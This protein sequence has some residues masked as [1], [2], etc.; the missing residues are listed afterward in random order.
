MKTMHTH[1]RWMIRRDMPEVLE[2]EEL[3]FGADAWIEDDFL[4]VLRQRN[5]V[6]MVLELGEK[7]VAFTFYELH[8]TTLELLRVVV[9]VKH[10]RRRLGR[11]MMEKM[12]SKLSTDR[13]TRVQ[14]TLRESNVEGQLFL[15]AC[16]FRAIKV[17]RGHYDDT[18]EDGYLMDY[19]LG[20]VVEEEKP[21]EE[22]KANPATGE[23]RISGW[24]RAK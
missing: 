11:Q 22:S 8:K 6:G 5:C 9:H 16:G 10:Q 14:M 7:V 18:G 24:F 13:R 2:I 1:I 17:L 15:R 12:A 20:R 4:R 3:A 21:N 23:N 19:K